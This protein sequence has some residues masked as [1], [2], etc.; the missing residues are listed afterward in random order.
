MKKYLVFCMVLAS[1]LFPVAALATK[2]PLG[3]EWL[4][5]QHRVMIRDYTR[6]G[7]QAEILDTIADINEILPKS[8]PRLEYRREKERSC[9]SLANGPLWD[10]TPAQIKKVALNEI[11]VCEGVLPQTIYGKVV[12]LTTW[13]P[14]EPGVFGGV[15]VGFDPDYALSYPDTIC[16]EFMHAVSGIPD[17]YGSE[18]GRS[19]VYGDLIDPGVF[20]IKWLRRVYR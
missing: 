9:D 5:E 8:A 11:A 2:M 12:G 20:D 16:H 17:N 14:K 7:Y 18:P 19:C 3:D 10:V 15:I 1:L 6:G 13:F 4:W